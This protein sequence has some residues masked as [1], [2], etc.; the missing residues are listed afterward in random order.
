MLPTISACL[1]TW[2]RPD[3][4]RRI[5]ER[6]VGEDCI[7]EVLVWRNDPAVAVELPW[8]KVRVIDSPANVICH[9]RYLCAEQAAYPLPFVRERKFW[10]SV[11]RIDNPF[12]DRNLFCTCPPIEEDRKKGG[13]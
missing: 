13:S 9:G 3:N 12:G 8:P 4:V 10:S 5:V 11:G 1:V 2:R 6:L 7:G